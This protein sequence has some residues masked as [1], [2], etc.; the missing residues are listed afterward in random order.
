MAHEIAFL[1]SPIFPTDVSFHQP[2]GA[3]FNTDVA[4]LESGREQ[5]NSFWPEHRRRF[6]LGYGPRLLGKAQLVNHIFRACRGMARGFRVRDWRDYKSVPIT[7]AGPEAESE[8]AISATDQVISIDRATTDIFQLIYT[9]RYGSFFERK[10]ITKPRVDTVLVAIEGVELG[11]TE[12]DLDYVPDDLA[13]LGHE[14]VGRITLGTNIQRTISNITNAPAAVVT[15]STAHGLTDGRSVHF[16]SDIGGMT[17]IR[18]QRGTI[19]GA[20]GSIFTVD[21]DTSAYSAFTTGGTLNTQRQNFAFGV[22]IIGIAKKALALVTSSGAHG[23]VAGDVGIFSGIGGMT[24]INSVE[25]TVVEVI[26]ASHFR[27]DVNSLLFSTFTGSG[28]FAVAERM[29]AGYIY[30][31]PVRFDTDHI[32]FSFEAWEAAGV[33]LP[34]IELRL[35]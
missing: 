16:G 1:E 35:I 27:V 5:R 13:A 9:S 8:D 7:R 2:G 11:P 17:Q 30:D 33:D 21:V 14:T 23:L 32:P 6:T 3:L 28:T 4:V 10:T 15:T 26:D 31:L 12:F 18:G 29:T 22:S 25:A 34:V 19:S 20:S 24:Q